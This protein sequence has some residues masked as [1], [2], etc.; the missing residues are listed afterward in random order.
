M[1]DVVT[2]S[3]GAARPQIEE[4]GLEVGRVELDS[5]RRSGPRSSRG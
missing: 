3:E 2:L 1:P 5:V 4:A